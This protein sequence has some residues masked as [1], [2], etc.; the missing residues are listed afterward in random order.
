MKIKLAILENDLNYLD[1]IVSIFNSRYSEKFEVYSFTDKKLALDIICTSKMDVFIASD[2]YTI[3]TEEIPVSCAF[4]YFVNTPGMETVGDQKAICKFQKIDV[5]YREILGLYS[6]NAGREATYKKSDDNCRMIMFTSPAGGVGTS[7]M[8][9]AAALRYAKQRKK[10]LYFNLEKTGA[11]DTFF[12]ADGTANMSDIL[13]AFKGKKSKL[14]FKLESCVK[15]DKSGVCFFSQ[16]KYALDMTELDN[17]DWMELLDAI[18]ATGTY[19]VII[20]DC[21]FSLTMEYFETYNYMDSIVW[22]GDGTEI[23]NNKLYRAYQACQMIEQEHDFEISKKILFAYNKFSSKTGRVI[24]E[25]TRVQ[26]I[27]GAPYYQ[28]ATN[29]QITEGLSDMKM[30]DALIQER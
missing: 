24:H 28:N 20:V 21:D 5:M 23:T 1:K 2:T 18:K 14:A 26:S 27:G 10:V 4:A 12:E 16:T 13:F 3:S 17:K 19:E 29:M 25:E 9:V 8:A 11:A 15:K 7:T 22:L 6:E 30:F